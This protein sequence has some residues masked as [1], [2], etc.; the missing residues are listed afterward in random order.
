MKRH[1]LLTAILVCWFGLS[2]LGRTQASPPQEKQAQAPIRVTTR[3]IQLSVVALDRKGAPVEGL[4]RQDFLVFENGKPQPVEVFEVEG[5]SLSAPSGPT[6]PANT[7]SNY[8]A[9]GARPNSITA[10]LLDG[11]NTRFVDRAVSRIHLVEFLKQLEPGDRIA[12]YALGATQLHILHDFTSDAN[13]LLQALEHHRVGLSPEMDASEPAP[14]D[15]GNDRLDAFLNQSNQMIGSY[16][17][18]RRV[19]VTLAALEFIANHL[20]S[21]P[22]RKNLVWLSGGFP[23]ALGFNSISTMASPLGARRSF[24][25]ERTRVVRALNASN[26]AIYPV[27][28]AGLENPYGG[29]FAASRSSLGRAYSSSWDKQGT[30]TDLADRTGGRAFFNTNDIRG[31]IRRAIDDSRF[32]YVLG[33]YPSNGNWDGKFRKIKVQVRRPG[34]ELRYRQGY[35]ALADPPL[36]QEDGERLMQATA[37]NPL[38]F[39]GVRFRVRATRFTAA[40][41]DHLKLEMQFVPQDFRL[42][43]RGSTYQGTLEYLFLQ[44]LRNGRTFAT[45][46]LRQDLTISESRYQE[47]LTEGMTLVRDFDLLAGA[48]LVMVVVR[49]PAIGNMGSVRIPLAKLLSETP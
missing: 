38:D 30:M 26:V 37:W 27:D 32:T 31:S 33:Y 3:L 18:E 49:N 14:A 24:T 5:N 25:E 45:P 16:W 17:V 46:V 40:G 42:Q 8:D 36:S 39:T 1:G 28:A 44:R 20:A 35:F 15:T 22:G 4:K 6:L 2:S 9:R 29:A 23:L 43:L 48:E 34:V 47:M 41:A 13:A 12:L 7:F 21:F 11:V 10:I 19:E